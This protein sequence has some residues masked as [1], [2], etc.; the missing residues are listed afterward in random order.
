M[1]KANTARTIIKDMAVGVA[2]SAVTIK[3]VTLQIVANP[4]PAEVVKKLPLQLLLL[5]VI[6]I[7][8]DGRLHLAMTAETRILL[9]LQARRLQ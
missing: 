2:P 9:V 1:L 4:S 6:K 8:D 7:L 5:E 3:R